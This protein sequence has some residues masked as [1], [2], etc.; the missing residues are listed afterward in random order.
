MGTVHRLADYRR[1]RHEEVRRRCLFGVTAIL[2]CIPWWVG[3]WLIGRE[4]I[5]LA[6]R[7]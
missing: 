5:R 1:R 6:W 2:V 4:L 7:W 3:A